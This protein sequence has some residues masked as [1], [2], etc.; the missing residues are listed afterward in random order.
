MLWPTICV[1]NFFDN[2]YQIKNYAKTLNYKKDLEGK[3]PGERTELIHLINQDL[4]LLTTKKILSLI[5]PMTWKKLAWKGD[6]YFQKIQ[7][8]VY[9]NKG[10]VHKD[11]DFEFTAIIYLSEHKECGTSIYH[12]KNFNN[13]IINTKD[14]E[15]KYKNQNLIEKENKLLLENNDRFEKTMNF[16]SKFNRLILFDGNQ[17]HAAEK[18]NEENVTEDRLTLI[19]FF[20]IINGEDIKFPISEMKRI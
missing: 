16:N 8:N 4:F 19:T 15:E 20:S 12:P 6:Q 14:K 10:W 3:W 18:F 17:Y 5:Y 7:G 2:A 11:D 1:D 9:K 13:T